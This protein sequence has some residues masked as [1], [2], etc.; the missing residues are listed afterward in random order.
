M[1]ARMGGLAPTLGLV[2]GFAVGYFVAWV[3]VAVVIVGTVIVLVSMR[4]RG[5]PRRSSK[6]VT[7]W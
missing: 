6:E 5:V 4:R 2:V 3:G 7:S 1:V